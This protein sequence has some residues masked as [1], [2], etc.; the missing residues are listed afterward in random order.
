MFEIYKALGEPFRRGSEPLK[1]GTTLAGFLGNRRP[2]LN[3]IT[4][5]QVFS[6][7]PLP[8]IRRPT[9]GE[10]ILRIY[11]TGSREARILLEILTAAA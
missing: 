11:S 10:A 5:A 1:H 2:Q 3:V 6:I 9:Q 8:Q 4:A 7:W